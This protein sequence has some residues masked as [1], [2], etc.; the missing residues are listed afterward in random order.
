MP[1]RER[2]DILLDTGS[3]REIGRLARSHHPEL[4]DRTPADGLICGSGRIEGRPVYVIAD[5]PLVLAGT[6][7]RVAEVK[8]AR[9]RA[10]ALAEDAPLIVLSEAGAARLQ[11]TRGAISA[12]LGEGFED[13]LRMSGRVPLVAVMMGAGFGGPSFLASISDATFLVRRTG[14]MGMS[15]PKVVKV[16]IGI[17]VTADDIGGVVMS[18]EVTGQAHYVGED[19][20]TTLLAVRRYLAYFPSHSGLKA[21]RQPARDAPS[22]NAEGAAEL[23]RL[24]P[25]NQRRAYS[26]LRLLQLI[27]DA[28]SLFELSA[29]YGRSMV[30][31]LGRLDGRVVGFIANN[32]AQG[33]GALTEKTATKQRHF[34]DLCDAFHIPL[35]FFTDTPG[36]L[37]GPE[38]E[39]HRM[40][41]LCGRLMNSL[42]SST[43]PKFTIVVR[44]AVGMAY[45]AMCGRS[46]KPHLIAAWPTAFFDVMGPEAGVMLLH[47]KEIAAAPDPIV[48]KQEILAS[49][50]EQASA[51]SA[52]ALGLIDDVITPLE[53]RQLL[54]EALKRSEDVAAP[55]AFKHRIDP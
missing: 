38:I 26:A 41:S 17:D 45:L 10:L 34:I 18:A 39:R 6:R 52:A 8:V 11:E 3:F 30:T 31:A 23:L 14:F 49:L 5:D 55:Y 50:Q 24:V 44:K 37:V 2:L 9:V 46:A 29:S 36:F 22:D 16:G 7:G 51:E 35:V 32:P 12:G 28:D 27:A 19:E 43:V 4:Y 1:V 21:P 42:L 15:G 13:H 33:A 53:T 47:D 54:I 25:E 20:E 48:R 40:V